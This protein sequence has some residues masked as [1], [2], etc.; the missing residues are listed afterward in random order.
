MPRMC[1]EPSRMR[2]S[3]VFGVDV[4][5]VASHVKLGDVGDSASEFHA[6]RAAADDDEAEG[7]VLAGLEHLAFGEL[8]GEQDAAADVGR[9]LN[10]FE[11]RS[12]LGPLGVAEVAMGGAGGD[13]EVSRRA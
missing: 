1:G 12:E 7:R 8:E 4:P 9:I 2:T 6:G 3:A 10:G 5:E 13:D 11:A